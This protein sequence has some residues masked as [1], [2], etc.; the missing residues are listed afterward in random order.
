[1]PVSQPNGDEHV[2]ENLDNGP[3]GSL[4]VREYDEPQSSPTYFHEYC[5]LN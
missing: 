5:S 1:M 4:R 3:T 2:D